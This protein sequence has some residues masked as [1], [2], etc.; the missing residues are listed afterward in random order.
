MTR[1]IKMEIRMHHE[2][3]RRRF[4]L[5]MIALQE[6]NSTNQRS[7]HCLFISD[8]DYRSQICALVFFVW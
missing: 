8:A 2:N 3:E 4:T 5:D 1:E 6:F 7:T